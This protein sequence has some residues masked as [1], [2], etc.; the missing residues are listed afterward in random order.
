LYRQHGHPFGALVARRSQI[1]SREANTMAT[2]AIVGAGYMGTALAYP[3][4]DN[5]HAVRLVGTHLDG[6][7][8]RSCLERR[9]HPK[10]K[11]QIPDAVQPYY[12]VDVG[13]ALDGADLVVSGVSSF[14]VRWIGQTIG[15][16]LRPGQAILS[17]TKG[18]EAT[19]DGDLRILPDV[20]AGE[21]PPDIRDRVAQAAVGGPCVAGELAGRRHSCVVFGSRDVDAAER[22]AALFRTSY[23]HVWTTADLVGL[24][25]CAALKNAYTIGVGAAAGAL[26]RAGTPTHN[27]A[28]AVFAQACVEMERLLHHVGGTR[29]FAYGLPG[30]GDLYV[31]CQ[32]GRSLRL[33]TLLGQGHSYAQAREI[34][35]GETVEA[36]ECVKTMGTAL[37]RLVA[38]GVLDADELPLMRALVAAIVQGQPVDLPVAA[39]FGPSDG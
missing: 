35:A 11:R 1:T 19:E 17:V 2:I 10:L 12:V 28:A 36:A 22:L 31:T 27:L 23:Y 4:T 5:G 39:F 15:P 34:M 25:V 38:R 21:L 16:Y 24:E 37:P 14:G 13:R 33:G 30:A 3:L 29:A 9:H 26:A 32:R 6:E 8:V 20:L 7:I 18:L